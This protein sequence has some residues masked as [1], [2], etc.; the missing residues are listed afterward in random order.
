MS[1]SQFILIRLCLV[2]QMR[3]DSFLDC[4]SFH[5]ELSVKQK[6]CLYQS[7]TIKATKK[8]EIDLLILRNRTQLLYKCY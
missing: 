3:I 4:R 6:D 8:T 7:K 2:A 1:V 5:F